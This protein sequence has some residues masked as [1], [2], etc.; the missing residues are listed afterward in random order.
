MKRWNWAVIS[1]LQKGKDIL[2]I[3]N[4]FIY[5]MSEI[6]TSNHSDKDLHNYHKWLEK[7]FSD[8]HYLLKSEKKYNQHHRKMPG[9]QVSQSW[10]FNMEVFDGSQSHI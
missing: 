6:W 8:I 9:I 5:L 7:G 10:T 4:D 2:K 1:R 3:A